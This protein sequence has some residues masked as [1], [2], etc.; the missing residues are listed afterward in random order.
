MLRIFSGYSSQ[1]FQEAVL[2]W[3]FHLEALFLQLF[4]FCLQ[5][6]NCLEGPETGYEVAL[7]VA[8]AA[9][10]AFTGGVEKPGVTGILSSRNAAV[11]SM[12]PWG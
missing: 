3:F 10:G 8:Y 1:F 12:S 11:M 2:R 7:Q 6:G 4:Q 9:H 5:E